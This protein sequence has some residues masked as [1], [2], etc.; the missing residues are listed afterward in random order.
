LQNG[1]DNAEKLSA[2]L[3]EYTIIKGMFPYNVVDRPG[4]HIRQG[5]RGILLSNLA[6]RRA[7]EHLLDSPAII[8]CFL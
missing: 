2:A 8:R 3:P 4:A 6:D 1:V 5:E 7:L